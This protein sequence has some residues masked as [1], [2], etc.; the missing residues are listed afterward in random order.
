MSFWNRVG[1]SAT[2]PWLGLTSVFVGGAAW[3]AGVVALGPAAAVAGG[4]YAVGA[5][6]GGL[7]KDKDDEAAKEPPL[8][9]LHRGTEQAQLVDNLTKY[10]ADL[11]ALREGPKPDAVVDPSIEALV[12]TENAFGTAVRVAAAVDGLDVALARSGAATGNQQV[13]EAVQRMADRRGA[14]LGKL[15]GTVDEVAEV[16]TKLLEMSATVSSLD[17]GV[18]AT[19][20]VEK[21]NNSLDS[22]RSSLAELEAQAQRPS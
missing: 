10:V 4:M 12:A 5:L 22:L 13:R 17:V 18:G 9:Q 16:Y 11:R 21:V 20:E 8:P 15:R 1:S 7:M 14:L 2:D 19:D 3:A 6:V